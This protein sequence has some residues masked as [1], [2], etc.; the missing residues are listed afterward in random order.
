MHSTYDKPRAWKT[1]L[2]RWQGEMS[3]EGSKT[4]KKE[5]KI[6]FLKEHNSV[7]GG[8]LSEDLESATMW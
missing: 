2:E 6:P 4:R 7:N 5:E 1:V 3:V 8:N